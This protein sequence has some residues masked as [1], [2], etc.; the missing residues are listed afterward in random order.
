MEIWKQIMG[1]EGIYEVSSYGNLRSVDR[2]VVCGGQVNKIK[3]TQKQQYLGTGGY[4]NARLSKGGVGY[5]YRVHRLVAM[6]FIENKENKRTVNHKNGIKTD[7]RVENLEWMTHSE[8]SRH[9]ID[10]LKRPCGRHFVGKSRFGK[11]NPNAKAI[12]QMDLNG[13]EIKSFDSGVDASRELNIGYKSISMVLTG[14]TK[15]TKGFKFKFK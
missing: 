2:V 14:Q 8:N 10:V 15:Q 12:V 4:L 9:A 1:F 11:D 5:H 13:N 3:G 6:N 7:N